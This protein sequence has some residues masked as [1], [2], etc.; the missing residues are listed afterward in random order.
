MEDF[1]EIERATSFLSSSQLRSEMFQ[2]LNTPGAI[3]R[4]ESPLPMTGGQVDLLYNHPNYIKMR[5][6]RKKLESE[7]RTNESEVRIRVIGTPGVGTSHYLAT[8]LLY[9]LIEKFDEPGFLA[10][11]APNKDTF[12]AFTRASGWYRVSCEL[13][14][15]KSAESKK[16]SYVFADRSVFEKYSGRVT[17]LASPPKDPNGR[18]D[19]RSHQSLLLPPWTLEELLDAH[20]KIRD[21]PWFR[22]I[23]AETDNV[24]EESIHRLFAIWGGIPRI[25]FRSDCWTDYSIPSL[26]RDVVDLTSDSLQTMRG[27]GGSELRHRIFHRAANPATLSIE[28]LRLECQYASPTVQ[29]LVQLS[30]AC[31]FVES[32]QSRVREHAQCVSE[33]AFTFLCLKLLCPRLQRPRLWR[34]QANEVKDES[35]ALYVADLVVGSVAKVTRRT[36]ETYKVELSNP[37][38]FT[39]PRNREFRLTSSKAMLFHDKDMDNTAVS[40]ASLF[41][42]LPPG[43]DAVMMSEPFVFLQFCNL[44]CCTSQ[45]ENELLD[46][47]YLLL[48]KFDIARTDRAHV[49][50]AERTRVNFFF[51]VPDQTLLG[52][53]S[54]E[55]EPIVA[56]YLAS[57]ACSCSEKQ[58]ENWKTGTL[59]AP[60]KGTFKKRV[61]RTEASDLVVDDPAPVPAVSEPDRLPETSTDSQPAV[62]DSEQDVADERCWYCKCLSH[63]HIRVLGIPAHYYYPSAKTKMGFKDDIYV[64]DSLGNIVVA[65]GARVA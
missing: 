28:G 19:R 61:Y 22:I 64:L 51:T 65:P 6:I 10:V 62:M 3:I 58:T 16:N 29:V 57:P 40:S 41:E 17:L 33:K 2:K 43:I 18:D 21:D 35:A 44:G 47:L 1:T 8:E 60:G 56:Q 36:P 15:G 5:N 4:L 14:L 50:S 11:F 24:T 38:V 46:S 42:E 45:A 49:S 23:P 39:L 53:F 20:S 32:L 12:Y 27:M 37:R 13:D 31:G 30:D 63:Y 48:K 59:T 52:Q 54:L 7:L 55:K 26:L 34:W 25:I 9:T